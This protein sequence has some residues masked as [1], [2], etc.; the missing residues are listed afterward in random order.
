MNEAKILAALKAKAQ[1]AAI[2]AGYTI[3]TLSDSATPKWRGTLKDS[4]GVR[5]NSDGDVE[6]FTGNSDTPYA[7]KQYGFFEGNE[8]PLNHEGDPESGYKDL[9]QGGADGGGAG[10]RAQY[11]RQY[12]RKRKEGILQKSAAK[13]YHR[14]LQDPEATREVFTVFKNRFKQ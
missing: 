4:K 13:W 3:N 1:N 9:S 7:G 11:Q 12:R 2:V 5:V 6:V 10:D 8:S 14:V